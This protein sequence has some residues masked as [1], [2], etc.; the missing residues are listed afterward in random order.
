MQTFNDVWGMVD[1]FCATKVGDV[2]Y[3]MW[4]HTIIPVDFKNGE[5]VL[6]VP[7]II[8]KKVIEQTYSELI[9]VA[10]QN[11]MGFPVGLRILCDETPE[12]TGNHAISAEPS[13][14]EYT[15]DTYIV[16]SS[17]RFAHAAS[18]A[19]AEKPSIVYNPLVIYGNSGVGK[20]H[21][22]LAIFNHVKHKYPEKN[23]LYVRS[24]E[25]INDF[26]SDVHEGRMAEFRERYRNVDILLIDDIQFIA[27]KDETQVEFFNT[28]NALHQNNKQIV[29]TSD[30][31]PKDIKALDERIRGRLESGL[32]ADI[33]PPE[34]ETRVGIIKR[35]AQMIGLDLD[36]DVVF[37]IAENIK[38][39]IRQLEGTVKKLQMSYQ[40]DG[41][42]PT[43]AYVQN[44]IRD[45]KNDFLPEPVTVAKIID[46]VSRTYG[47]TTDDIMSKKQNAPITKVRQICMYIVREITDMSLEEIGKNFGKNH[48]TVLHSI[49]KISSLMEA[50]PKE[51]NVI[52]DIIK[53]LQSNN[54]L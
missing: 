50:Q 46:E 2:A 19:V 24:E 8:H 34:F 17:N 48:A 13:G 26:I 36:D 15:F 54:S 1:E 33:A 47:M 53:N 49:N 3:N 42:T 14:Y 27:G 52:E 32:I 7:H 10:F 5:A 21:L 51:K 45:I 18:M 39:N 25:F 44:V 41:I 4:I 35:K 29:V 23:V 16:G 6:R 37:Y 22:M 9:K 20:T 11:I 30:R 12:V 31:P 38:Q 40:I 28:F 43:V